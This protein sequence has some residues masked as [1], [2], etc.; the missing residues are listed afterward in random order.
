V[1]GPLNLATRPF[2]NER[3]PTLALW[4]ALTLLLGLTVK[5][6]W[7]VAD[8]LSA[9]SVGLEHEV[10]ALDAE[11]V[12]LR[13]ER[14]KINAPNPDAAAVRQWAL[15]SSLVD[16]RAFSWTDLLGRLEQ[17]LPPGVHLV[18]IAPTIQKGQVALEFNAVARTPEEGLDLVKA[19]QSRKDFAEVFPTGLD[20]D[21]EGSQLGI[22]LRYIPAG[23]VPAPLGGR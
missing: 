9:R 15:V 22:S 7:M 18:S 17:V 3:L 8:L 10:R 13:A 19:L 20:K 1:N 5:H 4:A 16:R 6:G 11:A 21:K 12:A 14:L 23:G 2:R